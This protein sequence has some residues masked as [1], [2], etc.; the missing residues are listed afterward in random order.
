MM[1][2]MTDVGLYVHVPFCP[3]KCGY[4]D[5]ASHVPGPE[6]FSP[7]VDAL[8]LEMTA[9]IDGR[10]VRVDTIF[11]GGGTPTFLPADCLRRLFERLGG[12]AREHRASEFTVETNPGS[13]DDDKAEILRACGVNR[14]SMGAQSF[15]E[16]ELTVLERTHRPDQI[17]RTAALIRETGF[18]HFNIDLIFGV[19]GQS[20]ASWVESL[21][22]A[23][24]LGPDHLACYGLT[25]EPGTRLHEQATAGAV[26][27]MDED[28]E[29]MLY[30]TTMERLPAAGFAQYEISNFARPGARS[31]HN[32]RYWY[33][34]PTVGIG[35]AAASYIEGQRWRNVP[36]S[37][38]YVRRI[39]A[40]EAT[41]IDVETL[42]PMQ[43]AG[44]TAM[45]MLRLVEGLNRRRFREATG[46]DPMVLFAEAISRHRTAGRLIVEVERVALTPAGRLVA[47]SVMADFLNPSAS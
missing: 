22:R 8:L 6:E 1:E 29:A 20:E 34:L 17:A 25:Y 32:L 4:C 19:P 26:F 43:R 16:S 40:G 45:L 47:D 2:C 28:L 37:V 39:L 12:Y 9:A 18:P 13:L 44:E 7:L 41:A 23:I 46:F 38:E 3:S 33:N 15:S 42:D 24:D 30:R 5:F 27:T 35:P 10:G 11:V 36:E 14:I 21:G 31:L